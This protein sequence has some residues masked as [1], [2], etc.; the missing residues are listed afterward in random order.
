MEKKILAHHYNGILLSSLIKVFA[1]VFIYH[2]SMVASTVEKFHTIAICNHRVNII[3]L[4]VQ[5]MEAWRGETLFANW[6]NKFK[7]LGK[8]LPTYFLQYC[9]AIVDERIRFLWFIIFHLSIGIWLVRSWQTN[10]RN[11]T[12]EHCIA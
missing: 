9:Y 4:F 6:Q 10:E 7:V 2:V 8:C 3:L 12:K 1:Y 5:W 11:G